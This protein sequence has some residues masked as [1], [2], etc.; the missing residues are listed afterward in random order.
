MRD[1][2]TGTTDTVGPFDEVVL[3]TGTEP[4]GALADGLQARGVDVVRIG[5]WLSARCL[6]YATCDGQRAGRAV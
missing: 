2:L 1:L 5:D 4:D 3:C 6:Q